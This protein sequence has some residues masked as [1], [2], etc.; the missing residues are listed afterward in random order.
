G[1]ELTN[2]YVPTE[3]PIWSAAVTIDGEEAAH[4]PLGRPIW[5]TRV[6]V[7][8]GGLEPVP[9]GVVGELYI[10]GAGLARGYLRR[11]GLT[12]ERFVA[13]PYG[14]AGSRMYRSRSEEHTSE[15]QSPDQIVCR[16]LP[17]IKQ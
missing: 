13:D 12:A 11:A 2:R 6:Y 5:N 14:V 8:D 7:L 4:P 16:L 10:S 3:T 1:A 15:L 17:A 9:L